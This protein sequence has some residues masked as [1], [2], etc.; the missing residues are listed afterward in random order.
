MFD[1]VMPFGVALS[2]FELVPAHGLNLERVALVGLA[3][4]AAGLAVLVLGRRYL[5]PVPQDSGR[6]PTR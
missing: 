6:P 4:I 5:T 1:T 3:A 2:L